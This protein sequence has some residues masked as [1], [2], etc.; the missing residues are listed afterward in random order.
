[1]LHILFLQTTAVLL[2]CAYVFHSCQQPRLNAREE[3]RK[4]TAPQAQTP[5]VKLS[6]KVPTTHESS[7]AI[8]TMTSSSDSS[9]GH[10]GPATPS[11]D[12]QEQLMANASQGGA[13]A[14]ADTDTIM[15]EANSKEV[16][17][18]RL[19]TTPLGRTE[20]QQVAAKKTKKEGSSP[21]HKTWFASFTQAVAQIEQD[22][23]DEAAWDTMDQVLDQGAKSDFL[24]AS[25]MWPNDSNPDAQYEY[26]PL[27]YA[28]ARGLLELV[29]ELVGYRSIPVDTQTQD[30]KNTPLHLASSRGHLD[31]VQFLVDQGANLNLVDN[32]EGSALHYAAAG[33]K[34]EMN[35]EVIE[36]LIAKGAD[37]KKTIDSGTAMLG[38]AVIAGNMPVVEY[39]EDN[40]SNSTDPDIDIITN[41]ALMLAKYRLKQF[42]QEQG[43]QTQI[44]KILKNFLKTRQDKEINTAK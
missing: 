9:P 19:A 21:S 32:E 13:L 34:G 1:M 23:R 42:P 15:A 33:R 44:I 18:K 26:T 22:L 3:D 6:T 11:H 7:S 39:W 10:A 17:R 24:V 41:K 8:L 16:T 4:Q 36:Y 30:N 43:I 12:N 28:A 31:V 5:Q 40:Y 2:L 38:I 35:R 25:I 37:F 27:H 20:A 29:K 14:V